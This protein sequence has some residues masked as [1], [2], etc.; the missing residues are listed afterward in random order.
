MPKFTIANAGNV[1]V[2]AYLTLLAKGYTVRHEIHPKTGCET[3]YAENDSVRL[4]GEDPLALLGLA[5]IAEIRG[6]DWKALDD[7]I[8]SF[9][10]EFGLE[11]P[12]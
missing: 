10:R 3:W 9:L 7:Q 12:S 8:Q 11:D 2:P 5:G 4:I 1:V 6:N